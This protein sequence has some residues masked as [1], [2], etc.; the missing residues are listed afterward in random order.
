[1][2][3]RIRAGA[4]ALAVLAGLAPARADRL[5]LRRGGWIE[6]RGEW[7]IEGSRAVFVDAGGGLRSLPLDELASPA[8]APA[9]EPSREVS[10]A[11]WPAPEPIPEVRPLPAPAP[12]GRLRPRPLV[13]GCRLETPEP[14][15]APVLVCPER[16]DAR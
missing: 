5:P 13:A 9:R 10:L 2:R 14:G 4:A 11:A 16:A 7:R 6:T 12:A 8:A 1:M 15:A 3:P